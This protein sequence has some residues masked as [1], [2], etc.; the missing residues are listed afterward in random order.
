MFEGFNKFTES[1][2]ATLIMV[3]VYFV[4]MIPAMIIMVVA[5]IVPAAMA[6]QNGADG[7]AFAVFGF[8]AF[9][10]VLILMSIVSYLPF[11]F[12]YQLIAERGVSGVEAVKLSYRGV[13]RN[14]FGVIWMMIAMGFISFA[15]AAACFVP[16]LLLFPIMIGSLFVLYRDVYGGIP[17]AEV[18]PS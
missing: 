5:I 14:L 3:G 4:L 7:E 10:P 15:A 8:L 18:A 13:V 17:V 2:V 16:W 9:Y 1:I 6:E 12:A 11:L